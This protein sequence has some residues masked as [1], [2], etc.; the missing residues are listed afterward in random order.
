MKAPALHVDTQ[1]AN[2]SRRNRALERLGSQ[3][4]VAIRIL[5]QDLSRG[6]RSRRDGLQITN[7]GLRSHTW[8]EVGKFLYLMLTELVPGATIV[9]VK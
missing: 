5:I 1:P 9:A 3:L 6:A 2:V 4:V 7:D 8:K